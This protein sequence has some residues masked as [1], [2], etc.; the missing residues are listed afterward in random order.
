MRHLPANMTIN[1]PSS[2]HKAISTQKPPTSSPTDKNDLDLVEP[3][4]SGP[5]DAAATK[6][7]QT[8]S[9]WGRTS[10][11]PEWG[12]PPRIVG[13]DLRGKSTGACLRRCC[14]FHLLET[15]TGEPLHHRKLLHH[16]G[17]G[18]PSPPGAPTAAIYC[19]DLAQRLPPM[20]V[21]GEGR[22]GI[23]LATRSRVCLCHLRGH[24]GDGS[25]GKGLD[26]TM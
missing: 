25:G 23:G 5:A 2:W 10:R 26:L 7:Q 14:I 11:E 16:A 6:C 17:G 24:E 9:L 21:M 3:A 15:Q 19:L 4:I 20:T 18:M 13:D 22:Q 1:S 8:T 12:H